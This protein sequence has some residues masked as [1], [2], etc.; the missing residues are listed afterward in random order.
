MITSKSSFLN[1][2]LEVVK[3]FAELS[4]GSWPESSRACVSFV[5][6]SLIYVV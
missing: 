2:I 6:T 4:D 1:S 5:D 3:Q